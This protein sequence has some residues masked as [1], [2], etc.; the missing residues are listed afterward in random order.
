M[1]K[2][3]ENAN[4]EIL[5][6]SAD[7]VAGVAQD[8]ELKAKN[9]EPDRLMTYQY[10]KLALAN[11]RLEDENERL[12]DVHELRKEYIPRLF[13]LTC[14]WLIVVTVFLWRVAGGR[15]FYL[16]DNVLIA[17]ITSTTINVI[18]IFLIAARWLFPT[19]K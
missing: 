13:G 10:E 8:E 3:E 15:D 9:D 12:R 17:L 7:A 11:E 16:Y 18:G 1:S 19:Q 6:P 4:T 2:F 14:V 5:N